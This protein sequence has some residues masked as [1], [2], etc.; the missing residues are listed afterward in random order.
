MGT[1]GRDAC[2]WM[3]FALFLITFFLRGAARYAALI[4]MIFLALS[5]LYYCCWYLP[6][7]VRMSRDLGLNIAVLLPLNPLW[8][9]LL[10]GR[11]IQ[12]GFGRAFEVHVRS[13]KR[14]L[15]QYLQLFTADLG[16]AQNRFPGAIFLWESSTPLPLFVRRLIR[17][18][19][20]DGSAFLKDG[21][22]PVPRFPFTERELQKGR[23]KRG[24]IV[25]KTGTA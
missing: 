1:K 21:G 7:A 25:S 22:W 6:S 9:R 11:N 14:E 2:L 10:I 23:V 16:R 17:L 20:L 5:F 19:S 15:G 12:G 4:L 8:A 24:A 18:G 3:F 13:E